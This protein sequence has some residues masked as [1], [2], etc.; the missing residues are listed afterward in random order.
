M[1]EIKCGTFS[2]W[3]QVAVASGDTVNILGEKLKFVMASSFLSAL[4]G[5]DVVGSTSRSRMLVRK[6]SATNRK[7]AR[8]PV[9]KCR[10][11]GVS[12]VTHL[13]ADLG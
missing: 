2:W 6:A 1:P 4:T 9:F 7:I 13:A 3:I 5:I 12:T 11:N 8:V 10:R